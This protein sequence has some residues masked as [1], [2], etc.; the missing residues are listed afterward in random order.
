M[1]I[2]DSLVINLYG[3]PGAGKSTLAAGLFAKL[4]EDN[5]DCELVT[6]FVKENI[7]ENSK[8]ILKDRFYTSAVQYHRL[9]RLNGKVDVIITESPFMQSIVYNDV[10]KYEEYDKLIYK[11]YL[12]FDNLDF[13][14]ERGINKYSSVGRIHTK[15]E[16]LKKDNEIKSMIKKYN[17]DVIKLDRNIKSIIEIYTIIIKTLNSRNR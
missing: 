17:L 1:G 11:L 16:S 2:K 6:E 14:I 9:F 4:K 13:Y 15:E 3:G 12:E 8:D 7:W 5:I 10:I